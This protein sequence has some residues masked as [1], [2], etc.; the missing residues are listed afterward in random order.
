MKGFSRVGVAVL[1][2]ASLLMLVLAGPSAGHGPKPKPGPLT[3]KAIMFASDGMRPD[4]ME[5]YADK[6]LMPTYKELL[7][8]GV[9]GRNG[10]EQGFPPNTGVGWYTL[11][12][13]TWPGEHGSTNNTFHRNGAPFDST[14]SFATPGILQADTLLQSAERSG[15]KIAS[16]E[17]VGARGLAPAVQGPVVDFRTFFGAR[18]IMLNYDLPGQPALANSFGVQYQRQTLADATG[19]TSVPASFSLAKETSFTQNSATLPGGGVWDVYIYDSTNDATVNYDR[20]LVVNRSNSKNGS[21]AAAT[22]SRG[23]WADVKVTIASGTFAGKTAGFLM[24]VIDMTPDLSKFRLYFTSAARANATYNA[25]GPTGSADF[26]ETLNHDFPSSTA[27]DF[28]PLEALIIDED[29]YA[30]QGLK[31]A[32]AHFAYLRYIFE[33]L[34]YRPDLLFLG[35]PTTDEFQH[36]FMALVTPTDPDGRPNPYYDDVNGDGTKD[37]LIP[38]REGYIRA[39]YHEADETLA[40]GRELMGKKDTTVFA[41]SDHG[42][43]PQWLAINARKLLFETTV[44]GVSVHPSGNPANGAAALSNCRAQNPADLAKACWAGGTT[45]VYVN[46]TLPAG[47]T[48]EAVRTAVINKFQGLTDPSTPGR[49]VI[50]KIMKKEELRNV[51]GT[52]SLH[53]NR[54]GDVVV[55]SRPPY[56]FDAAT[57]GQTIAFSQFFGQHG[58]LPETVDLRRNI[59]MHATFVAAGPGI[60]HRSSG[61]SGIR[62]IDVAPTLAFVMGI[63]GPQN[64]RGK[65]LYRILKGKGS[66]RELTLLNISDWHAQLTPLSDTAD[67]V[68]PPGTNPAFAIGGAAFLKP[69][70]DVYRAEARDG[71]LT[72]TGGDSFG[73]ATPPISNAFGDKPTPP[74]MNTMG[75]DAEAVG[76]H[77]FD[78]G[79]AYFRHELIP[80]ADFDILSANVVDGTTGR[81][82]PEW[83]PSATYRFGDVRIG[84]VGFTTKDTPALLFPG[85]LGPFVVND[86]VAPINAEAARIDRRVDAVVALGHEGANAGALQDA[87]GPLIDIADSVQNVDAMIGDHNDVQVLS[88]RPNGVLV[89]ENRGKGIR[90][91]RIRLVIDEDAGQVVYKTADFH[92]PWNIGVT[93]DPGIQ[94]KIDQLNADLQPIFGTQIGASNVFIPRGDPCGSAVG[95]KCES[96][97][98]NT[99]TDAIRKSYNK[100]FAITNSGGLRADLTCPNPDIPGDF[101]AA[102]TPPPYPITRGQ[103]FSVLPFGNIVVTLPVNG[104]ELKTMLENGVSFVPA[105]NGRFPQVSGLCFTYDVQQAAGNRVTSAVR[106]AADGSCTGPPV[107]LTAAGG[108]YS[109]LENDF[110]ANGGDG[111]PNF[112]SRIATLDLMDQVVADYVTAN[113]PLSPAIQGRIA[114]SDSDTAAAPACP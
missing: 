3:E 27:A 70:F 85:R 66:L 47:I 61:L 59:N 102:Y 65:I 20:V 108:P 52:D 17:W 67:N 15:K 12:T 98:G 56:Q 77:S 28:A 35:T 109:I 114:C 90:F 38:K 101:C 14:T 23:Q 82:P 18:G 79:E 10:L 26:E 96:L 49:Q 33:D 84:V 97:I 30:E 29:T 36:Q 25:L 21:L 80:L 64:A 5:R 106:Q 69:W 81:T 13:G 54:S 6:G 105:E 55:V 50:L 43:A 45:Q 51:D 62:A 111:Y 92:R 88:Y 78:R 104:A 87:T 89:T 113:S 2:A 93:P 24:K 110:M 73:G 19:W 57:A 91:T 74:I 112:S 16:V 94:A 58:Y 71:S 9:R 48:Y 8:K 103:V 100:D 22:L 60:R 44:N 40:L 41:S 72:L 76:N 75:V 107:D 39:A 95:R 46:P 11:A 4:L 1:A 53:P 83:S 68:P 34:G 31:W 7:K 63:Q 99:V 42:F 37:N 32:D 86:P